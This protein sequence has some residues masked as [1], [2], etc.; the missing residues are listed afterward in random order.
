MR[1]VF[2]ANDRNAD[3]IVARP[4]WWH[5]RLETRTLPTYVARVTGNDIAARKNQFSHVDAPNC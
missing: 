3:G 2:V 5:K 4:L 1:Q